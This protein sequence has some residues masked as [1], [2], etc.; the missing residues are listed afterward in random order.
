MRR[1]EG[2]PPLPS[3]TIDEA[4]SRLPTSD[5]VLNQNRDKWKSQGQM[6]DRRWTN[7]SAR[8]KWTVLIQLLSRV[9]EDVK[10]ETTIRLLPCTH[11]Y[12]H[13]IFLT[14]T[15]Q[16]VHSIFLTCT[17]Q[18][19]H[20]IFLTCTDQFIRIGEMAVKLE[21]GPCECKEI[22]NA[23]SIITTISEQRKTFSLQHSSNRNNKTQQNL[24]T[25]TSESV[26]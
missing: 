10:L 4:N 13:R 17:D 25:K 14:Y 3:T 12:I 26:Q 22:D 16:F 18:F 15:D 9:H 5:L 6:E 2:L 24:Y 7:G 23:I 11:Q 21:R 19:V 8:D 1:R 20:S